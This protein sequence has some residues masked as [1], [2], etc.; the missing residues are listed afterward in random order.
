MT[1]GLCIFTC[2]NFINTVQFCS[3]AELRFSDAVPIYRGHSDNN[4]NVHH[5]YA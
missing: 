2:F 3:H 5:N 4:R 1:L